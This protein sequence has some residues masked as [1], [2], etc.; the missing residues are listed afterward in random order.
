[1]SCD[2]KTNFMVRVACLLILTSSHAYSTGLK[3][4]GVYLT[5]SSYEGGTQEARALRS[6]LVRRGRRPP[7]QDVRRSPL[8]STELPQLEERAAVPR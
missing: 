5:V 7:Q 6:Q 2:M 1:V 3:Q 4:R 8:G